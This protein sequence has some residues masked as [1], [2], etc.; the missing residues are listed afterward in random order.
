MAI[1]SV[2]KRDLAGM[3]VS[4][5]VDTT[6]SVRPL[7]NLGTMRSF[8]DKDMEPFKTPLIDGV[9]S[10]EKLTEK[11]FN[12]M[13][14]PKLRKFAEDNDIDTTEITD[15]QNLRKTIIKHMEELELEEEEV[16]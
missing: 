14:K 12:K 11:D 7:D 9:E 4:P 13:S 6:S 3:Q 16:D 10:L 15:V 2:S 8:E 1:Q 5:E